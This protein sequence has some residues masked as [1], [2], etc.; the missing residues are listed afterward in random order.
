MV[1]RAV[2]F[3]KKLFFLSLALS[4][5]I[6]YLGWPITAASADTTTKN[7]DL[8]ARL[9]INYSLAQAFEEKSLLAMSK[10]EALTKKN[11]EDVSAQIEYRNALLYALEAQRLPLPEGKKA[12]ADESLQRLLAIK[13][14]QI[15]SELY[16]TPHYETEYDDPDVAV[17]MF[18]GHLGG[19]Y[20]GG[21][22]DIA[23]SADGK[24]LASVSADESIRLW[25]VQTGKTVNIISNGGFVSE[26]AYSPVEQQIA[27]GFEESIRVWNPHTGELLRTLEGHTDRIH[28][29]AYSPDGKI[30]ASN[31]SDN[32]LRLW[33]A[34]SGKL[35]KVIDIRAPIDIAFSPDGAK[36]IATTYADEGIPII[37]V[38]SGQIIKFLSVESTFG[39]IGAITFSP[40]GKLIAG[41]SKTRSA[42]M[43]WNSETD[44]IFNFKKN[45]ST[46]LNSLAFN[47]DSSKLVSSYQLSSIHSQFTDHHFVTLWDINTRKVLNNFGSH[48]SGMRAVT[49]S[50]DGKTIAS[51]SGDGAIRFWKV[52]TPETSAIADG[53][54]TFSPDSQKLAYNINNKI[55]LR[56]AY[57]GRIK[58]ELSGHTG[59]LATD[60]HGIIP[61]GNAAIYSPDGKTIV[62]VSD[63]KVINFWDVGSRSLLRSHTISEGFI[64]RLSY[65]PDGKFIAVELDAS[66]DHEIRSKGIILNIK[67]GETM[68]FPNKP[69]VGTASFS[70]FVFSHDGNFIAAIERTQSQRIKIWDANTSEL[71]KMHLH[72]SEGSIFDLVFSPDNEKI[73]YQANFFQR[74]GEFQDVTHKFYVSALDIKSGKIIE[75]NQYCSFSSDIMACTLNFSLNGKWFVTSETSYGDTYSTNLWDSSTFIK[76][77][78]F[79][80]QGP[81]YGALPSPDGRSIVG[82][83]IFRV[84]NP[85]YNLLYQFDAVEVSGALQFLWKLKLD[86]VNFKYFPRPRSL[87]PQNGRHIAWTNTTRKYQSLMEMPQGDKGKLEQ[88]VGWLAAR[89]AYKRP[90]LYNCKP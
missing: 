74:V 51:S 19:V 78:R 2:T 28:D 35:I 59:L 1:N 27:T 75:N 15:A 64:N 65:K 45:N 13:K 72:N 43:V 44:E 37:S 84:D 60:D 31:A 26:L 71:V 12:L 38:H 77:H 53:P 30:I 17:E 18:S 81:S 76:T 36:I 29:I 79:E 73:F 69:D 39:N 16:Q 90:E 34:E 47:H 67:T 89:C 11:P 23:Y 10:A 85:L 46:D 22:Y 32:T 7:Q 55:Q 4:L 21:V 8:E 42:I 63:R 61:G 62:A 82:N 66:T 25:N 80:E 58:A 52:E 20:G 40:N 88:V 57:T 9:A 14:H 3:K 33:D 68:I 5:T 83:R 54:F 87:V 41:G 70:S 24:Y 56:D 49:F 6:L 50:P 48:H 86:G